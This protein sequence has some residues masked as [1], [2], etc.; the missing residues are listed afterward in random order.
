MQ[1][2]RILVIDATGKVGLWENRQQ[3]AKTL[4]AWP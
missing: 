3:K 1:P 2:R 4:A